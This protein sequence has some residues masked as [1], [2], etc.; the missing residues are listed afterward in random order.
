VLSKP[1]VVGFARH[2][3]RAMP[4]QLILPAFATMLNKAMLDMALR[5]EMPFG[6]DN[7]G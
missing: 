5:S 6:F 7:L 2:D 4:A 3:C 1:I